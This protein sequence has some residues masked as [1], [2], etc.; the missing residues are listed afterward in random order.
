MKVCSVRDCERKVYGRGFCSM[1]WKRWYRYG[2]PSIV[3]PHTPPKRKCA[4]ENC[5]RWRHAEGF[6]IAHFKRLQRHG[7]PLAGGPFRNHT[8][9]RE[10]LMGMV[11]VQPNGCWRWKGAVISTGY[12]HMRHKGQYV[13]AH[14]FAYE[15]LV[16]PIPAG[17]ALDHLCHNRDLS[18]RFPA[19]CLHRLCV[20]PTHL[21]PVTYGE[22]NQR[23]WDRVG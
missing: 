11:E 16:G 4:V 18:C 23:A 20:N 12:G 17:L 13:V 7:D 15:L 1:H 21:E 14:R 22:N 5:D 9:D 8:H 10:W 3:L 19:P 2:D 6:C